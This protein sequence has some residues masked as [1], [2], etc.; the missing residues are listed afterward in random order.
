MALQ[1]LTL[2]TRY[3]V[4]PLVIAIAST[5][6]LGAAVSP[7]AAEHPDDANDYTE[8]YNFTINSVSPSDHYPGE[9]NGSIQYSAAGGD[10]YRDIGMEEGLFLDT[11]FIDSPGWLDYSDCTIDTIA[12]FGIDRGNNNTGTQI[13]QDLVKSQRRTIFRDDGLTILMYNFEDFTADPPYLA[14]EDAIVADQ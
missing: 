9:E 5:M 7:V 4:V 8:S 14:P 13:D 10:A 11:I 6:I 12:V 1:K 3:L 2:S